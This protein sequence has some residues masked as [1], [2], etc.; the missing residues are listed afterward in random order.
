MGGYLTL[1]FIDCANSSSF[2]GFPE[3]FS[4]WIVVLQSGAYSPMNTS[5]SFSGVNRC[6]L[7]GML[8]INLAHEHGKKTDVDIS[9][10]HTRGE[11]LGA[12]RLHAP[13]SVYAN[14]CKQ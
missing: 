2:G 7:I 3:T 4:T 11:G 10:R 14:T 6:L 8:A 1:T 12:C 5:I 9:T 13:R